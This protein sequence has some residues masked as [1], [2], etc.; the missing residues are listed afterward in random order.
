MRS[1]REFN[2]AFHY[3]VNQLGN[4]VHGLEMIVKYLKQ[5]WS[6]GA[7]NALEKDCRRIL[8]KTPRERLSQELVGKLRG[9]SLLGEEEEPQEQ[10]PSRRKAPSNSV[11]ILLVDRRP[12]PSGLVR[13]LWMEPAKP[14]VQTA[15]FPAETED[16]FRKALSEGCRAAERELEGVGV[17][18]VYKIPEDYEFH[19]ESGTFGENPRMQEPSSWLACALSYFSFW[20][21]LPIPG[22]NAATGYLDKEG[23]IGELKGVREKIAAC[24]RERPDVQKILVL[25]REEIPEPYRDN[26]R[27]I[28]VGSLEG[29]LEELWGPGWKVRV[30]PPKLSTYAAVDKALHVY[31]KE[32][33]FTEAITR[34][35]LLGRFFEQTAQ[36]PARFRFVCDWRIASCHT[37][38]GRPD[39]AGPLFA[40]WETRA[41]S[42]WQEGEISTEDYTNFFASYGVYL[43]DVFAF[44]QGAELLRK[45]LD[46]ALKFKVTRLQRAKVVGTLGQ[47]L[48]F[49]G[50]FEEAERYLL[51]A[52]DLIEE[53]EKPRNCT[54]LGQLYTLWKR[55]DLGRKYL[56]ETLRINAGLSL[57]NQ[58]RANERFNGVWQARLSYECGD[59]AQAVETAERT[60]ALRP[61]D[62]PG[63]LAWKWKGMAHLARG[64][65]KEGHAAL[66]ESVT[67]HPPAYF[68]ESPNVRLIM[69][70]A[71]IEL[72]KFCLEKG[73]A[74]PDGLSFQAGEILAALGAFRDARP[75]FA[76]EIESLKEFSRSGSTDTEPL[77]R[78]LKTLTAKIVY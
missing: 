42:L 24:L 54:Y 57:P 73:K 70:T 34:F 31:G 26:L 21:G 63:C 38:L 11:L 16:D 36:F 41:E 62:Y 44:G 32:Q 35:S 2:K 71:R 18:P 74:C 47:I 23:Q 76:A 1:E 46:Q 3:H 17:L 64:E 60:L 43:Q 14:Y 48:M 27:V 15:G 78:T 9:L 65:E 68:R 13:E 56:D 10:E 72:L 59:Y 51:Q 45:V 5:N 4:L 58:Q 37:H 40:K 55:Y 28:R 12:Q 67:F 8:G 7:H 29:A 77:L 22:V 30:S 66:Q 50:E 19:V 61:L 20:S 69:N 25:S 75:Y 52:Y 6:H 33:N 39:L 53:E 49:K